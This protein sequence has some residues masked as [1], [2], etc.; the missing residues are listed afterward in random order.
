MTKQEIKTKQELEQIVQELRGLKIMREELDNEVKALENI[1]I[2]YMT[3]HEL[4]TEMTSD[5][6]ITY[7][8]Q[9]RETVN[10][11]EVKKLLSEEDYQRVSKVSVYNVLRIK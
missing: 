10:K 1:I 7:K 5:S 6:K 2:A 3:E 11:D 8:P 9:T 4:D